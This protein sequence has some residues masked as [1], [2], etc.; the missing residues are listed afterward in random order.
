MKVKKPFI[1]IW[2]S[3]YDGIPEKHIFRLGGMSVKVESHNMNTVT[4]VCYWTA[5]PSNEG[6]AVAW[7]DNYCDAIGAVKDFSISQGLNGTVL[8]P[9]ELKKACDW[10]D[11]QR[12]LF[13]ESLLNNG[14]V[15]QVQREKSNEVER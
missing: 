6:G 4:I 9:S 11:E 5:S 15:R 8:N 2:K 13:A 1:D 14:E 3:I 7:A 12:V 10:V